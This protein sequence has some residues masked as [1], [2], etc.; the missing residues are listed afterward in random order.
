MKKTGKTPAV[1]LAEGAALHGFRVRA[2][3]PLPRMRSVAYLLAHEKSGARLLHVHAADPENLFAIALRTPPPDDTGL[4]HILEHTVLCGSERFPVKDPFVE[5][6]KSSLATFLNAMTYPDRTVYPCASLVEKD[7]YNLASVYCDAVF[8]P[9]LREE[10]FRQ[11]GHHLFFAA[12]G[13]PESPLIVK[14]IVYNEMK[15]VYSDLDGLIDRHITKSISP[16]NAYGRDSGGDP[17]A[18][19]SLTFEAFRAFHARY[20]HPSNAYF[21][22]YGDLPTEKHLAFLD[23]ECLHAF[24][25]IEIDTAIPPQRRW[26]EPLRRAIPYPVGARES[27]ERKAAAVV[28]FLTNDAVDTVRTFAM[29][30][31]DTL[32][33]DNAASPL[34]K[35]LIDSRL[36]EELTNA[37][38]DAQQRDTYFTVGLK[39]VRPED[40]EAVLEVVQS[41]CRA[42]A[43]GGLGKERVERSLHQLELSA[44]EIQDE[45]PLHLMDRVFRSWLYDADPFQNLRLEE[46]LSELRRRIEGEERF[47]ERI[48]EEAVVRNPHYSLLTFV[49]DPAYIGRK[50]CE[51]AERMSA[52]KRAFSPEALD[53]IAREAKALEEGQAIPNS[54]EALATLP[55]LGKADIPPEPADFDTSE[56]VLSGRPFLYSDVFAGGLSY[57]HIAFDLGGL[58]DELVDALP[59]FAEAVQK[60]GAGDDDYVR[61][62][63]READSSGGVA[64]SFSTSGHALDPL[65]VQPFLAVH[66]KA[67]DEKLPAML[68]MLFDRILRADFRDRGRFADVLRQGRIARR[69]HLVP[70]GSLFAAL[71]AGRHLSQN[72][73]LAERLGGVSQVLR[74]DRWVEGLEGETDRLV[75]ALE[76]IR[77]FLLARG[78]ATVSYVGAEENLPLLQGRLGAFLDALPPGG[79]EPSTGDYRPRLHAREGLAVPS[80]VAFVAQ[81]FPVVGVD[82]PDA[83][84]LLL[85]SLQLSFG[86]LWE[87]VRVKGGAYGGSARY[88]PYDAVFHFTSY[89]DPHIHETLEAF[90]G[91]ADYVRS[92]MDLSPSAVEQ[93]IVGTVKTLDRPIRPA[94]AGAVALARFLQGSTPERRRSFRKRLLAL[95]GCDIRRAAEE[96]LAPALAS[97]PISV[98]ASREELE[99]ANRDAPARPFEI[100]D[101]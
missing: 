39:G 45:H 93:A 74:Y 92:R 89:R 96:H 50:A 87:A 83:P 51:A 71:R 8:H 70:A 28:T 20:Y 77:A 37:G 27:A 6:L 64:V 26:S 14:G 16:D 25:R 69:S 11:E 29:H 85:L 5:L 4:P 97:A 42:L 80:E 48:L 13:D 57:L 52:R 23:R 56:R 41:T 98:L 12:P 68:E 86:Y 30:L 73:A 100:L 24:D 62:A 15:G 36:G 101:V 18:I 53:R 99:R 40:A 44:R 9:R 84:A 46:Q 32:L 22:L 63:E 58:P 47:L 88:R 1:T 55:R 33:L 3:A 10:H 7:F 81:A 2:V 49:P 21:F 60:M 75:K 90:A 95:N 17:D 54:P 91:A 35:A 31:L 72:G 94:A 78:R 66:A 59:L 19:P 38:Y 43:I 67:L 76:R 34:R 79:P 82:H 61:M 65:R